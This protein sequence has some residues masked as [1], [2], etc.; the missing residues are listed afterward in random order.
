MKIISTLAAAAGLVALSA[1]GG[2]AA[3]ENTGETLE[4]NTLVVDNVTDMN[5]GMDANAM[6]DLNTMNTDVNATND[7][8]MTVDNAT[9]GNTTY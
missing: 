6:G 1:C 5:M 2:G 7:M 8:N 9:T 4:A 3:E